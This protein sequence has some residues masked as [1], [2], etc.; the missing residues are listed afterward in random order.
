VTHVE[1]QQ[2]WCWY[3]DTGLLSAT[4]QGKAKEI[5]TC[6][7]GF[8]AAFPTVFF[9]FRDR[10]PSSVNER[11]N[12]DIQA[13]KEE[14]G[15]SAV[16]QDIYIRRQNAV[17]VTVQHIHPVRFRRPGP[18]FIITKYKGLESYLVGSSW[19]RTDVNNL[20]GGREVMAVLVKLLRLCQVVLN[21]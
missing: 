13:S 3:Q 5:L 20:K 11:L 14:A 21:S 4:K 6:V 9:R 1:M 12:D 15:G 16:G 7:F 18:G 17:R 2:T 19:G 8:A 10:E